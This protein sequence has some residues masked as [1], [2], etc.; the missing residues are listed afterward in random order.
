DF[1]THHL[2]ES[3]LLGD[4]SRAKD[5][6]ASAQALIARLQTIE[7]KS[8]LQNRYDYYLSMINCWEEYSTLVGVEP[9]PDWCAAKGEQ[10][11][12]W[13]IIYYQH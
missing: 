6:L 13:S 3:V 5:S 4:I 2:S 9:F 7:S 10:F 8:R 11:D 1:Q 12:F